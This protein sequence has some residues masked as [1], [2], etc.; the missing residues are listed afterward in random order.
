MEVQGRCRRRRAPHVVAVAD[1]GRVGEQVAHR[2]RHVRRRRD[3]HVERQ[4]AVDVRIEVE[5]AVLD[6]GHDPRA[7]ERL[8]D[9]REHVLRVGPARILRSMFAQPTPVDHTIC[10]PRT[11]ANVAPGVPSRAP[12]RGRTPRGRCVRAVAGTQERERRDG[13]GARDRGARDEVTAAQATFVC[14]TGRVGVGWRSRGRRPPCSAPLEEVC[15]FEA[16]WR[17]QEPMRCRRRRARRHETAMSGVFP[18][19]DVRGFA[20]ATG[21]DPVGACGGG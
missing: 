8:R 9:R 2:D 14:S 13:R 11:T 6:E 17:A 16:S 1:R 21:I 4:I 20:F 19:A 15:R 3:V 5:D 18:R 10:S 7:R 12:S